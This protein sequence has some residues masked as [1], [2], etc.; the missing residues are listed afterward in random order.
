MKQADASAKSRR[1]ETSRAR[2]QIFS[3]ARELFYRDGIR[4]VGVDTIV[5]ESGVAKTS[6]YRWFSTKDDLITAFL[7]EENAAFWDH[8]DKVSEGVSAGPR[9]ELIAHVDWIGSYIR[10]PRFR[11]CPFLNFVAEFPDANHP[12]RNVC[13]ANKRELRRRL[14]ELA[15]K[16][17]L[18]KPEQLADG[19]VLL[20]EGGF[21]DSQVL[22]KSGPVQVLMD[23]ALSLINAHSVK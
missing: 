10:G 20:I 22:G 11:G 8:W 14:S 9:K 3:T 7:D 2:D 15:S 18:K 17:S 5:K 6:L 13:R 23:A 1:K 16:A 12:A 21:S 19:L 4:A